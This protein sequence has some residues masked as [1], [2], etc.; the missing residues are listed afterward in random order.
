MR[1]FLPSLV[2]LSCTEPDPVEPTVRPSILPVD[3]VQ[4][5]DALTC[6]GPPGPVRWT[7]DGAPVDGDEPGG[8]RIAADRT[9]LG[10][11]WR[12]EA[13]TGSQVTSATTRVEPL[14]GNVV[15]FVLDDV[16]VEKIGAYGQL[17]DAPPHTPV[18]DGLA[19][20]GIRFDRAWAAPV[21]SPTR[22]A[23]LT[24]RHARRTGIGWLVDDGTS[25]EILAYDETFI[26][27]MLAWSD[28]PYA[29]AMTGK[30]HLA[31]LAADNAD[32]PS[33]GAG[34]AYHSGPLDNLERAVQVQAP[35]NYFHW[36]NNQN[37]DLQVSWTYATR[38]TLTQAAELT[39]AMPEPWFLY[40]A[41][42][43]AHIPYH[44]P[45]DDLV[46]APAV[47]ASAP[48]RF[49][50]MTESADI[51]IGR[52]LDGMGPDLRARTTIFV[53]GDNGT[54]AD[55]RLPAGGPAKGSISE[56]G[57]RV[58]FI[59]HGHG[60]RSP[61]VSNAL[62]HVVDVFDTVAAIAGA[63]L[64]AMDAAGAL[65][66]DARSLLPVLG[67]LAAPVREVNYAD[68]FLPNGPPPYLLAQ[69]AVTDGRY[70]LVADHPTGARHLFDLGSDP[71][72]QTDLFDAPPDDALP[73]LQALERALAA[74]GEQLVY[75]AP[76][77]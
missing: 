64:T 35:R 51:A 15:V 5:R 17:D 65:P 6:V 55:S 22:A 37:G 30:W 14:L 19:S 45:P 4:G 41:F 13:G 56:R 31:R 40:V 39:R 76:L 73:R 72:E 46:Y 9:R 33:V 7:V 25:P 67:D 2:L 38:H 16:G 23:L 50:A 8:R 68:V 74:Y 63:D 54:A 44:D 10:R 52:V 69:R 57:I 18:I 75:D 24:G 61:G 34:F 43:A 21:C 1:A 48:E 27:E 28:T 71:E 29:A 32:H 3:A 59:V 20:T 66:R 47:D 62:V 58:P 12:C 49:R 36:E 53:I 70:K 42:N 26:P 77:Q 11:E 60:V